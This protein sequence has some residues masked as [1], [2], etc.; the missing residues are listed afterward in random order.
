L[1]LPNTE[2]VASRV[3]VLPTGTAIGP[4]EVSGICR[5][6]RLA[7]S[8]PQKVNQQINPSRPA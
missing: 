7:L 6:I 4:D 1:L 8:N 2:C 3:M 5:V